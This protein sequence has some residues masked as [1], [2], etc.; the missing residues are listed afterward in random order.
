MLV[1]GIMFS[2]N[3]ML[4]KALRSATSGGP[5]VLWYCWCHL[6]SVE[7]LSGQEPRL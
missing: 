4:R 5:F 1:R 7:L 3:A 2:P 6:R